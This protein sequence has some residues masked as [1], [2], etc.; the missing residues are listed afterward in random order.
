MR[1]KKRIK[2]ASKADP[3]WNDREEPAT[4]SAK[5]DNKERKDCKPPTEKEGLPRPENRP[6]AEKKKRDSEGQT[7][8][9]Q[10]KQRKQAGASVGEGGKAKKNPFHS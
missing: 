9:R 7:V 5:V 3:E 2:K 10:K 4:F 8:Q 6:K 1:K